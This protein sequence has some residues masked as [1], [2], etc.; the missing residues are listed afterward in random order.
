MK[1][2]AQTLIKSTIQ[3]APFAL[4]LSKDD[5]ME[6]GPKRKVLL[7]NRVFVGKLEAHYCRQVPGHN[8][9]ML[10]FMCAADCT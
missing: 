2:G 9:Y 7:G 4:E 5:N 1:K 6:A 8:V 3:I 10:M